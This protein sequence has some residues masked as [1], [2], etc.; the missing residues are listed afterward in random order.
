MVD[1]LDC[2][3]LE[4]EDYDHI[5]NVFTTLRERAIGSAESVGEFVK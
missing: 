2:E 3:Q 4:E 5:D 1:I